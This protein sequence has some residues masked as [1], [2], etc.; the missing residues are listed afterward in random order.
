MPDEIAWLDGYHARIW[1]EIGPLLADDADRRW[2][3]AATAPLA[4][5]ST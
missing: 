2:L 4:A 1:T 3:Q 5:S